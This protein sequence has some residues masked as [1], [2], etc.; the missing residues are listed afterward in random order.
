MRLHLRACWARPLTALLGVAIGVIVL[1]VARLQVPNLPVQLAVATTALGA[2]GAAAAVAWGVAA[3]PP[4]PFAH[5]AARDRALLVLP[6]FAAAAVGAYV[7]LLPIALI[8]GTWR[9][10]VL[11]LTLCLGVA[12]I[13]AALAGPSGCVAPVVWAASVPL[14]GRP[15]PMPWLPLYD[16]TVTPA[17]AAAAGLLVTVGAAALASPRLARRPRL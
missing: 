6:Q 14:A 16:A 10:L 8:A 7:V 2:A 1:Y 11:Q 5:H 4:P 15:L 9:T 17:E 12:C 13:G 3:S